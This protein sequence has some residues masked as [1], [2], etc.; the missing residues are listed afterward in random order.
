MQELHVL[1]QITHFEQ[2]K[3]QQEIEG[4]IYRI[5]EK[6]L[7]RFAIKNECRFVLQVSREENEA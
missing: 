2:L 1:T 4:F 7:V 5:K 3:I 6:F